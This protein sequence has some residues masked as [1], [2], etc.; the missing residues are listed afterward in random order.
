MPSDNLYWD[1]CIFV[2]FL[3]NNKAAYGH[4]IDHI[5]HF[6]DDAKD[7]ACTIYTSAITIA[8][9]TQKHLVNSSYGNFSDFLADFGGA[10][11]QVS[12]DPNV[13]MLASAIRGLT[14]AK[15]GGTREVGT[16]DAIHLASALVLQSNYGVRI[17]SF[18]TFDD[19]KSSGLRG[20]SVPLLSYETW[21]ESCASDPIAQRVIALTRSRPDHPTPKLPLPTPPSPPHSA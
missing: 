14:Y 10:I 5:G 1:T 11:R 3:N 21:C 8:E 18:H 15:S 9:I 16:P 12:A 2:A 13:M 7:G 4:Y 19:G 17:T 20:K 6:L